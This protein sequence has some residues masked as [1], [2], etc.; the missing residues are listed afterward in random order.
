VPIFWRETAVGWR[1]YSDLQNFE[2]EEHV[3]REQI[4]DGDETTMT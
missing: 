3:E 1:K 2:A 4:Q